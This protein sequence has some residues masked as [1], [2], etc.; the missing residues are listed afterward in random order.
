MRKLSLFVIVLHL[1]GSLFAQR[2][3]LGL[4]YG[5]FWAPYKFIDYGTGYLNQSKSNYN[6]FPSFSFNRTILKN[7]SFEGTF[8]YTQYE[9]YYSTRKYIPALH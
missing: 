8:F 4:F 9:Q 2:N 7:F 1:S 6:F 3:D 5:R